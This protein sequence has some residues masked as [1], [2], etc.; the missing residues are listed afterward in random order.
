MPIDEEKHLSVAAPEAIS[1]T[2]SEIGIGLGNEVPHGN[3]RLLRHHAV[4][5]DVELG[6]ARQSEVGVGDPPG[7]EAHHP[8]DQGGTEVFSAK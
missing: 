7:G 4:T 6:G 3:G 2:S 5:E 1:S 8:L